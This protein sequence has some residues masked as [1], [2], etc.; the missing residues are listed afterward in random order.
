M[1]KNAFFTPFEDFTADF[2]LPDRFTF[3][4]CYDPHPVSLLAVEMLQAHL[5]NQQ[6]WQHNFG[7]SDDTENIIGKM[8]GV[9]VVETEDAEIGYIAAFSGK[10]AGGNH[11]ARFVPPI[12][13]GVAADG[14]LNAGMTA[15]SRMNDEIN[16]LEFLENELLRSQI[17]DLKGLRKKHSVA[18]QHAI[19]DQYNFLNQAG[20]Q[21]SL[22]ALFADAFYKN[23]PAGA[24][25]CAAPKL[26]QY[27]FQNKMRPLALAEFWWGMSPKSDFWKHKH[28]YPAC[29]EKCAPILAHMLSGIEMDANPVSEN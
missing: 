25:E 10:L 27:A 22:R 9:L 14:F 23:P 21:K 11:H 5:E 2:P 8:F 15:L 12:F 24:G 18:L 13:D 26:L 1:S 3:P 6:D 20:E 19:F 7:L 4:F 28:F 17:S 16:Q 29:R